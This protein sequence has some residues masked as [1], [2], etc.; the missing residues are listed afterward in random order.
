MEPL[1]WTGAL[2][3]VL[4]PLLAVT[5]AAFALAIVLS[6]LAGLLAPAPTLMVNPDGTL[7]AR[8]GPRGL[9]DLAVKASG[10]A[11]ALVILAYVVGGIVLP[12]GSG[13]I[14]GSV[15]RRFL[16]V[17]IALVLTFAMS[18]RFKRHLGLYGRLF[19]S[20][21]GMVGFGLVMFWVYTA[22]AVGAFDLLATHAPLSQVSGLKNKVPGVPVPGAET[23]GPGS[24][25]LL[26]GDNLAR[27]VFSRMV[28]GSW[29]VVQIA[30]LATLFSFMVGI[31]LG[32]PAGYYG[33]RTDA[34]LSFLAEKH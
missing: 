20:P 11:L 4:N 17:W 30:P 27:D 14:V 6:I 13:G 12:W 33:G 3:A 2:G 7:I 18:I 24:H 31:T 34:I 32:L 22:L 9:A 28:H 29:I 8:G 16:P 19:D 15:V 25:Y 23:M 5:A 1:T 21:V 26:G 10:A